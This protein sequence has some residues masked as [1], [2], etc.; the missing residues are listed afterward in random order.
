[1]IPGPQSRAFAQL[2][3]VS[4]ESSGVRESQARRHQ[5]RRGTA[6]QIWLG[7][8]N[9]IYTGLAG[10]LRCPHMEGGSRGCSFCQL[11]SSYGTSLDLEQNRSSIILFLIFPPNPNSH[12][13]TT[14]QPTTK[15][16][17]DHDSIL[18]LGLHLIQHQCY[19]RSRRMSSGGPPAID[20]H[21]PGSDDLAFWANL[22]ATFR[23]KFGDM[24]SAQERS[25]PSAA[26]GKLGIDLFCRR[27]P[28]PLPRRSGTPSR[29]G[30]WRPRLPKG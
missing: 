30:S 17:L 1:M 12:N 19:H 26:I 14:S 21:P 2:W 6:R 9:T 28:R 16:N 18:L 8:T 10:Q 4:L 13:T 29:R 24:V 25:R 22:A 15:K 20:F 23:H 5:A 7:Q 3:L 27:Q 11:Q